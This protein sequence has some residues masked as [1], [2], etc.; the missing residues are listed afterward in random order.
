MFFQVSKTTSSLPKRSTIVYNKDN[1]LR[2]FAESGGFECERIGWAGECWGL[3]EVARWIGKGTTGG[4]VCAVR[5]AAILRW[6]VERPACCKADNHSQC[7]L[8]V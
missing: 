3:S 5:S 6:P 7:G 8:R 4:V 1:G 2:V